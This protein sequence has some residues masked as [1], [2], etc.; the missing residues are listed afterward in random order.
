MK[1]LKIIGGL[2]AWA[3]LTLVQVAVLI[4]LG[5]LAFQLAK[6]VVADTGDI[7]H[8]VA[9]AV[10]IISAVIGLEVGL[11]RTP[12]RWARWS[13]NPIFTAWPAGL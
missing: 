2:I 4:G 3:A 1:V 7:L 8:L 11:K 5:L 10:L 12:L 9:T 6:R 13:E